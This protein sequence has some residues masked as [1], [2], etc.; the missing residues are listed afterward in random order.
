MSRRQWILLI[1]GL[2]AM[3]LFA[4]LGWALAQ[5][6]GNPGGLGVNSRL[7]EVAATNQ[8]VP[9]FVVTSLNGAEIDIK[10]LRGKVVMIDFWSSWC[11]PCR[12]EAP[13]L[14]QVYREYEGQPVAFI[15]IAIWDNS[16]DILKFADEFN[17]Q[18]PNAIDSEGRI[19]FEYGVTGIPQ[20][21]FIDSSGTLVRKYVGPMNATTLRQVLDEML[22]NESLGLTRIS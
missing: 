4:L 3:A 13:I 5:S 2:P 6:G 19:A 17:V 18:Y 8:P 21:F 9:Q 7:G 20:K 12:A 1:G 14:S 15:G 11:G 22:D 16:S 10:A